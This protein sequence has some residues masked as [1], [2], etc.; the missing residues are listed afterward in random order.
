MNNYKIVWST[1]AEETY[2]QI[3][4]YILE[5]WGIK[6][7]ENFD[8][9]VENLLLRLRYNKHICPSSKIQKRLRR[10]VVSPQTSMVYKINKERIIEIVA[11][12]DNRSNHKY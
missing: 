1:F 12:F 8:N 3:L 4:T 5:N 7:A 10:C 2:L 9:K 6:E 11:F